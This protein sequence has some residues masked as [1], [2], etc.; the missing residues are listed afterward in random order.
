M[1]RRIKRKTALLMS[2]SLILLLGTLWIHFFHKLAIDLTDPAQKIEVFSDSQH[3]GIQCS[4]IEKTKQSE[5]GCYFSYRVGETTAF[6]Y[7]G[8]AVAT[9]PKTFW[10]LRLYDRLLVEIEPQETDNFTLLLSSYLPGYSR[11]TEDISWRIFETNIEVDARATYAVPLDNF[12]TPTWWFG[13][14]ALEPSTDRSGLATI[15]EIHIQSHPLA[16]RGETLEISIESL[17]F[18]HSFRQLLPLY[19]LSLLFFLSGLWA[20]KGSASLLPTYKK[21]D[22]VD[23][24]SEEFSRIVTYMGESYCRWDLTLYKCS[25]EIGITERIIRSLFKLN[26]TSFKQYLTAIRMEEG[27]RILLESDRNISEIASVVG[28]KH[29]TTFTRLFR[30]RYGSSPRDF[31]EKER[32]SS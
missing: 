20:Q 13:S 14:N 28:Y 23:K 27:R 8:F 32:I 4:T 17:V 3:K 26:N 7:V 21:L 2:S 18:V 16:P 9:S 6:P 1:V 31:R 19:L 5:H 22:I 10:D 29:P 24:K 15:G 11:T 12:K 30:E 25:L